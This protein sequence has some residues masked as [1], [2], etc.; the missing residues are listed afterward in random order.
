MRSIAV[1]FNDEEIAALAAYFG[2]LTPTRQPDPT[3]SSM[4]PKRTEETAAQ[5]CHRART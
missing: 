1:K 2:S 4:T 5:P 3:T